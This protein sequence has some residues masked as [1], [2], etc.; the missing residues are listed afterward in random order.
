MLAVAVAVLVVIPEEDLL[1]L[2]F[3]I[4]SEAKNP[5]FCICCCR[6]IWAGGPHQYPPQKLG[7]PS[8]DSPDVGI[9]ESDPLPPISIAE[10]KRLLPIPS[11]THPQLPVIGK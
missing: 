8:L 3:V 9:R 10:T 11:A 7:A 6:C 1:L 4:L 5:R 2:L